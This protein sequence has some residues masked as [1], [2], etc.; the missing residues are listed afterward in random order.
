MDI[1]GKA[2][3]PTDGNAKA[4][5]LEA[6]GTV[7]GV[8]AKGAEAGQTLSAF[9][10][11]VE[12]PEVDVYYHTKEIWDNVKEKSPVLMIARNARTN[13]DGIW[14]HV[15]YRGFKYQVGEYPDQ[16][17]A[18]SSDMMGLYAD[19]MLIRKELSYPTDFLREDKFNYYSGR[20]VIVL[21]TAPYN[22]ERDWETFNQAVVDAVAAMCGDDPSK[23][24]DK[25]GDVLRE[26]LGENAAFVM[27]V[28]ADECRKRVNWTVKE[29]EPTDVKLRIE[30]RKKGWKLMGDDFDERSDETVQAKTGQL[31]YDGFIGLC[32]TEIT[33]DQIVFRNGKEERILTPGE[34]LHY[35]LN[36]SYEDHEG[37]EHY[38][39]DYYL[40]ITW[41]SE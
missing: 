31:L 29:G 24:W 13:E 39:I 16:P 33:P 19:L 7:V 4:I 32:I 41:L 36:D 27:I 37:V 12:K 8:V 35:H 17:Y 1:I 11:E 2:F 3:N 6:D 40:H 22:R 15:Y 38:D 26:A 23:N 10:Q 25:A 18:L 20:D 14:R 21:S 34:T 28:D 9:R 5:V 30:W